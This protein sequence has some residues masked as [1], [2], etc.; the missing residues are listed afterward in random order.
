MTH[1]EVA[2]YPA[3]VCGTDANRSERAPSRRSVGHRAPP[4]PFAVQAEETFLGVVPSDSG[5]RLL[6]RAQPAPA[7]GATAFETTAM[8]RIANVPRG[9]RRG[10]RVPTSARV[11]CGRAAASICRLWKRARENI[12]PILAGFKPS[13]PARIRTDF[14]L[15]LL[16]DELASRQARPFHAKQGHR[17]LTYPVGNKPKI[18]VTG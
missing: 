14:S 16:D 6:P 1:R 12:P 10:K 9:C 3:G 8:P 13:T 7:A 5:W 18:T 4:S 11:A 17:R 15:L 2:G